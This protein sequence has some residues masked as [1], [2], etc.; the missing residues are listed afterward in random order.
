M[1]SPGSDRRRLWI[2]RLGWAALLLVAAGVGSVAYLYTMVTYTPPPPPPPQVSPQ[3]AERS[4]RQLQE[5][6]VA[7]R[8]HAQTRPPAPYRLQIRSDDINAYLSAQAPPAHGLPAGIESVRDVRVAFEGGRIVVTGTVTAWGRQVHTTVSGR[9]VPDGSGSL[10]FL[11]DEMM[12]GKMP[13][14]AQMR[15]EAARR[16]QQELQKILAETGVSVHSI[17]ATSG[18]MV[19]EG[20]TTGQRSR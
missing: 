6:V 12:I 8:R 4:V 11:P 3:Q 9:V 18:S 16:I 7:I 20:M 15:S 17:E 5:Q 14:P 13:M 1:R 19:I 10:A 2:R